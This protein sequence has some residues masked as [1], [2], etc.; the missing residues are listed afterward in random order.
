MLYKKSCEE[1][2]K[3]ELFQNPTSEYRGTPFWAWNASLDRSELREQIDI[4]H[5]MGFGGF[6]MHVRQGLE[7]PYLSEEFLDA[8]EC[9]VEKAKKEDMLAW[10]YD[11]DRWPS[12]YAGGFVT[13]QKKYR[14]KYLLM[15]KKDRVTTDD[16]SQA[17]EEGLDYFLGAFDMVL[18]E[19]GKMI[20]YEKVAR[21]AAAGNK[22]YY[23]LCTQQGGE[24][25][26]NYQSYVDVMSE[27]A[28]DEFLRVTYDAYK[29]RI[30]SEFGK[31][32]PAIFTDEPMLFRTVLMSSGFSENDAKLSWTG[33]FAMTYQQEFGE[34]V[35][36]YLPE[37]FFTSDAVHAKVTKYQYYRHV[38][39]RFAKGYMDRIGKWCG[40][41]G[42]A[43]TG[44]MM[45][46]D[47]L[48]SSVGYNGDVMRMY[49]EMQIPGIDML[50]NKQHYVT[51]KQC[52]SVVRQYGKEGMLSELYG[53]TG[54]DFDFRGHKFQGD[55]QTCLGV[56]VRVP[57]LAWQTM[58]GEGKR[59]YPASIFYQS[60]W[61]KEYKE[62]EDH[63]ARVNTAMT[64][65][66]PV[67]NT[68]VLHPVESFWLYCGSKAET[69]I[70]RHEME[71]HFKELAHWLLTGSIDFDYLSES[72][73]ED[74]C[75]EAGNPL[76]VG[77]MKYETIIV[78]DCMTLRP[79]TIALLKTFA[80]RGG[81][82]IFMG[83]TPYLSLAQPSGD[84]ESLVKEGMIL[85]Y[86]KSMLYEALSDQHEV[87]IRH[88]N[89]YMTE[90]LMYQLRKD[91]TDKWL[92]VANTEKPELAH[93]SRKRDICI[94]VKG[95]FKPYLYDTLSGEIREVS[96]INAGKET[97]IYASVYNNT[98]LLF[99][100]EKWTQASGYTNE[101][102]LDFSEEMPVPSEVNF[103]LEEPNVLLLDMAEFSVDDG[104]LQPIEEMMRIDDRVRKQLK[105]TSRRF[106]VV[107]PWVIRDTPEDHKLKLIFHIESQIA[108]PNPILA[109]ENPDKAA[110]VWNGETV[111][112]KKCGYYVDKYIHTVPLPELKCGENILEIEM[113][114][115]LRT[116]L[117]SCY[118]L[119]HFGT[120]CAGRKT[121]ITELPE[122][123]QFGSVVN[124]GLAFYSG[125]VKY[126]TQLTLEK[127]SDVE[128]EISYYRAAMIK[129]LVDGEER[130]SIAYAPYQLV[131]ENISAGSHEI[132]YICYGNRYNTFAALH[133]LIADQEYP[134]ITP[135]FWRS[136]GQ[137]WSY[138]YQQRSMGILKTPIVRVRSK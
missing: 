36:E 74:L 79:H 38:S 110:I 129:V 107:Q 102:E 30:G 2:L 39:E 83:K 120:Y 137:E 134:N 54:W 131:L 106:K 45:G 63:F 22:W 111:T 69:S 49:K 109:I 16:Y 94:T 13:E 118:L 84:A 90:N 52:Q 136:E 89:G 51:A 65:G 64:R 73:L 1:S 124:Q 108:Y 116:D 81:K 35:L 14:Q 10:L 62:I 9:C 32:V 5:E 78:A 70:E 101:K 133:S 67:V 37:L 103:E 44:H 113:P 99:K 91:G 47:L 93:I 114:F 8:V 3:Q 61:Y 75:P 119:G 76:C 87:M 138:E 42:I 19:Q 123:I 48:D 20:S 50:F 127:D 31:T 121:V 15:T 80:R 104:P 117:E 112:A 66:V 58:K 105:L 72:L 126:H 130:G 4:F 100:L 18:D 96:Y 26:Y 82:L 122:K 55:W 125:N 77:K 95:V 27:E 59:D 68:A 7:T 25:R 56:T 17:C 85:P 28:T 6:H 46:E 71:T 24:P 21:E 88:Q 23:F 92:F 29:G 33:D 128:I 98:S 132:T 11:E 12:G 60:P 97:R 86:S 57:H 43:F 34:E 115:G 135:D 41:H 53:V 40:E